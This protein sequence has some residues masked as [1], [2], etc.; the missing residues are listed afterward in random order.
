MYLWLGHTFCFQK[1]VSIPVAL[2]PT[3]EFSLTD[4]THCM[5]LG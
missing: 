1:M 5:Y 2:W 3:L 4:M